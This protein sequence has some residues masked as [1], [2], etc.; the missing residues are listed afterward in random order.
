MRWFGAMKA[1]FSRIAT[2]LAAVFAALPLHAEE[3]PLDTL[4]L[5]VGKAALV[6]GV[7]GGAV[8]L[9]DRSY[10]ELPDSASFRA[11]TGLT[12]LVSCNPMITGS[13]QAMIA[14]KN[15]YD[16]D[17]REWGVM[18][19]D[20]GRFRLYLWQGGWETI[21]SGFPA[22]PGR[23][24]RVGVVLGPGHAELWIDGT[25]VGEKDLGKALEPTAAPVTVGGVG[26]SHRDRPSPVPWM[27]SGSSGAPCPR[28]R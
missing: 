22:Q 9:G 2:S 17:E 25:K 23:W 8:A 10:L 7:T 3:W 5:V 20:D 27:R 19:D 18:I 4:D 12:L 16:R 21:A 26:G 11:D 13:A 24:Y 6:P 1:S 28:R 14:A 15:R